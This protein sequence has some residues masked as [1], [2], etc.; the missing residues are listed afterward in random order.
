V[1]K[2]ILLAT[3]ALVYCA[4]AY[5][6]AVFAQA[7]QVVDR[8][9]AV[10]DL[11]YIF[12][13]YP[14]FQEAKAVI[15]N[16]VKAEEEAIKGQKAQLESVKKQ[17]DEARRGTTDYER[18]DGQLT[19]LQVSLQARIQQSRKRFME[20]EAFAY[21]NA[22]KEIVQEVDGYARSRGFS[23]VLRF[24]NDVLNDDEVTEVR[25]V[26]KQLNK[27]VVWIIP[28]VPETNDPNWVFDQRNRNI[29]PAILEILKRRYPGAGAAGPVGS[30]RLPTRPRYGTGVD[31]SP[32]RA[33]IGATRRIVD[34]TFAAEFRKPGRP[35]FR[36]ILA[37][38]CSLDVCLP[39]S[40]H[41][42][43]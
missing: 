1:K 34:P 3:C 2:T 33:R 19:Q 41:A 43:S 30:N 6:P 15:D 22:Y 17:R 18:L 16:D 36:P 4:C 13:K 29:T 25:E 12:E 39:Q 31:S 37:H 20:R 40:A 23:M 10:I 5:A 8:G 7:Q 42:C 32:R 35:K 9:V 38:D 11:R 14:R 27:P 24:N 21:A 26:A 28:N